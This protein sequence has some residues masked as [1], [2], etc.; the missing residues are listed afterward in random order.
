MAEEK[1]EKQGTKLVQVLA[2]ALAAVTAAFLGSTLGVAGTVV[3]AALASVVTTVGGEIYLRSLDRTRQLAATRFR[4]PSDVSNV[5]DQETVQFSPPDSAVSEKPAWR[6]RLPLILGVSAIAFVVALV[7]ITGV[8]GATGKTFGGGNGTTIGKIV[9]GDRAKPGEDKHTETPS[10]PPSTPVTT[11]VTAP[12]STTT[13]PP[14][15][16]SSSPPPTTSSSPSS[17]SP[18]TTPSAPSSTPTP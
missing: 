4:A 11:T 1:T 5:S 14:P 13:P 7:A 15:T 10:T 17:S 9:G 6:R 3:G 2:A 12:P 8:E 16:T 18:A